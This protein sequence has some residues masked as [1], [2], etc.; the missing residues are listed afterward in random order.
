MYPSH[1]VPPTHLKPIKVSPLRLLVCLFPLLPPP[2]LTTV[3]IRL[4]P[5]HLELPTF[6]LA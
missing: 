5:P 6:T 3:P 2:V 4:R 1:P